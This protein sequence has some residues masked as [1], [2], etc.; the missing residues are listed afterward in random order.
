MLGYIDNN[1]WKNK[2][3][4]IWQGVGG[5]SNRILGIL[6]NYMLKYQISCFVQN[7]NFTPQSWSWLALFFW[8]DCYLYHEGRTKPHNPFV[9]CGV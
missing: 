3:I 4:K 6:N 9:S 7:V 8:L 5:G 2:L 1:H